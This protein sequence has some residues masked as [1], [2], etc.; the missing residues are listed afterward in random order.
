MAEPEP[1][2]LPSTLPETITIT[3][4]PDVRMT[5]N[6]MRALK[7]ET[8]H[9]LEELMGDTADDADR[10]QTLVWLELRRHGHNAR[11]SEVGDVGVEFQSEPPDPTTSGGSPSLP[12][13]AATGE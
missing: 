7:A 10:M 13:S 8:G 6:Q 2:R 3:G 5:P 11:W 1:V 9:T 4:Q 12:D